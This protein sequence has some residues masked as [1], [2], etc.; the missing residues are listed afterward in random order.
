[1]I[2]APQSM[3]FWAACFTPRALPRAL[4]A[5]EPHPLAPISHH[6]AEWWEV[7]LALRAPPENFV[8]LSRILLEGFQVTP[9]S[10]LVEFAA[11]DNYPSACF[12]QPELEA[13]LTE[14]V[15]LG[16]LAKVHISQMV[17]PLCVHP[18]TFVP[19]QANLANSTSSPI[20]RLWPEPPST[21]L[22]LLPSFLN[23]QGLEF[24]RVWRFMWGGKINVAHDFRN[25]L[26][27][28]LFMGHLAFWVGDYFYF[29]LRLLF[30]FTWSPFVWNSFSDYIQRYCALHGI[31]C[32][33]YCDNFLILAL[34]KRDCFSDIS[35]LL[36]VLCL[37]GVPVKL[38]K[39]IW[40][41]QSI[42]F[43]GLVLDFVAMTVLASLGRVD[44]I[45]VI[46]EDFLS[47]KSV[48]FSKFERLVGKLF[49]VAQIIS[50]GRT[51]L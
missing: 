20:S 17:S 34:N 26:L 40:P 47:R 24:C 15:A 28:L 48:P 49:F 51:F 46:L 25:I 22:P 7:L 38:S 13:Y 4:V 5:N 11:L 1:M 21:T 50:S 31:N 16:H 8:W 3:A 44:S 35:F 45:L 30:G 43:L 10:V 23:G 19:S 6:L 41:S 29:E 32:V 14:D 37:L 27:A 39:I 2:A 42:E 12:L 33:V 36:E 9:S 18:I